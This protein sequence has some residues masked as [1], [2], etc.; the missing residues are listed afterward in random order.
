MKYILTH[1]DRGW[2]PCKDGAEITAPFA[3]EIEAQLYAEH[4]FVEGNCGVYAIINRV[5][6]EKY[7]GQSKNIS[8]RYQMHLT[9]LRSGDHA[10]RNLQRAFIQYGEDSFGLETL[11]SSPVDNL[12]LAELR[13][14]SKL[15]PEYNLE[16]KRGRPPIHGE[17]LKQVAIWFPT[18]MIAWLKTQ[19][20]TMSET[21]R[22]LI[23]QAMK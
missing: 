8:R 2:T 9:D 18:E 21:M 7:I 23:D 22:G 17:K 4:H 3:T 13:W 20:G 14:I 12:A 1:D 16:K 15:S 6:G 19:P 10:N 5:T 11:E